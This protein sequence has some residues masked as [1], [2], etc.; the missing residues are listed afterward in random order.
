MEEFYN[1]ITKH[2]EPEQVELWFRANNII[3]ERMDLYYDFCQSL[4]LLI[5]DTY[6]GEE[7]DEKETKVE[8]NSEDNKK[9]FKWCWD[10]N[11][12]N[13]I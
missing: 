5:I 10:K 13:F 7:L 12:E 6:L 11:I 4:Y 9:H 8:M 1:Y 3:P 2:L